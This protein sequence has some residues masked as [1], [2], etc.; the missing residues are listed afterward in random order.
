MDARST[1]TPNVSH[2]TVCLSSPVRARFGRALQMAQFDPHSGLIYMITTNSLDRGTT[3]FLYKQDFP[4][5][6]AV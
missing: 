1:N 2:L 4:S 3:V 5:D 6:T